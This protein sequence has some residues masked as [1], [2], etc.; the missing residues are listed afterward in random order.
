MKNVE[1]M[2]S[3][4]NSIMA[5]GKGLT[6]AFGYHLNHDWKFIELIQGGVIFHIL[7]QKI[8]NRN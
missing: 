8:R 2:G 3:V 6:I 5:C 4:L 1:N 7:A